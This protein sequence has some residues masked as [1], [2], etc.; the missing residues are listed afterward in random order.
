MSLVMKSRAGDSGLKS[1]RGAEGLDWL[2][3][4]G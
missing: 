1:G 2:M 3:G 4:L